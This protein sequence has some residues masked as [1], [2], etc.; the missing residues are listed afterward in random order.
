MGGIIDIRAPGRPPRGEHWLDEP[1][2]TPVSAG[3]VGQIFGI[4]LD[5]AT[6]PN[7]YVGATAAFGLHLAADGRQWMAGMWGRDGGPG[8]IYRLDAA[9]NYQPRV[10]ANVTLNGRPNTGAALGNLAFDRAHRQLFASDLETGFIHRFREADGV[11]LGAYDHGTQGR[12]RFVDA[13]S[14][15]LKSLPPLVFDPATRARIADCPAGDFAR[16]PECWNLAASGRRTWGIAVR[17]DVR[18][19]EVRLYYSVWSGPGPGATDWSR[20]PDDEKQNA[21]WSVRIA[22]DGAFDLTDVRRE[23]LV[24]AFFTRPEEVARWGYSH[25]VSD[26]AFSECGDRNV[27]LL[28]ER[29]GLRNLGL[30]A[31]N[32]FARPHEARALRYALDAGGGWRAAG[33]Y[34]VGFYDRRG[35]GQPY[36]RANCA[37]GVAFGY[38]YSPGDWSID[39]ARPDQT[40]WLSGDVLCSAK[41]PCFAPGSEAAVDGSEVNGIQGTPAGMADELLPPEAARAYP[42][43]GPPYPPVGLAQSYLID[44]DINVGSDGQVERSGLTRNDATRIGDVAIYEPCAREAQAPPPPVPRPAAPARPS[45][46]TLLKRQVDPAC[47]PGSACTFEVMVTNVGTDVWSGLLRLM[48][49]PPLGTA[50]LSAS[51]PWRCVAIGDQ[52]ACDYPQGVLYPGQQLGLTL[53]MQLPL[54][55]PQGSLNCVEGTCIV[56]TTTPP[57]PPSAP[58]LTV[59]KSQVEEVCAPGGACSFNVVLAN[60]SPG[61]WSGIPRII[62]TLPPGT[63][64]LSASEP[65]ACAPL[66]EQVACE[67]PETALNPGDWLV[68]T[69]TVQLPADM[70]QGSVNCADD[71]CIVITSTPPFPPPAPPPNIT[72]TKAQVEPACT[73]G[74]PCTFNVVLTNSGAGVFADTARVTDTLP[75]G[76]TAL[77]AS[78]PWACAPDGLQVTC[79]YPGAVLNPGEA[80]TLTLTVQLPPDLPAGS[81]NCAEGA[82]IPINTT[83]PTPVPTPIPTPTPTPIPTP[84]PTP[85]PTP[86]TPRPGSCDEALHPG[87]DTPETI[88]IAVTNRPGQA[89]FKFNT[90]SKKDRILV[91]VDGQNVLDTTCVGSEGTRDVPLTLPPGAQNVRVRVEPNCEPGTGTGTQWELQ[92]V[93]PPAPQPPA[94]PLISRP[95]PSYSPPA[96]VRPPVVRSPPP[97]VYVPPVHAPPPAVYAPPLY[98]PPDEVPPDYVPPPTIYE[99]PVYPLPPL[100]VPPVYVPPVYVP[101]LGPPH[102]PPVLPPRPPGHCEPGQV[103]PPLPGGHPPGVGPLLPPTP[104]VRPPGGHLPGTSPLLPP[105]PGVRPPGGHLPGT[106]PLLPPTPG[107][108]PPGGHLPG[109]SPLLPPTPGVRP[110]G[111]HMP[112][113][114]PLLPPT[115]GVRP[116]GGH[117]PGTSP[118]LPPTPG[119]RPPGG[120]LPGTS[121]LLPPTPGVRPPGGHLPGTSPL[122]PPTP[123]VRPPGGHLPGTSPLLPPTPGVRPPGGHLPGAPATLPAPGARPP[124][125]HLPGAPATLPA[126]GA[127]PP[128][129]HLPGAPTTLPTQPG[130]RP[131]S[132]LLPGARPP[133]A[134]AALPTQPGAHPPGVRAPSG[135]LTGPTRPGLRPANRPVP[136]APGP[137][138]R[139]QTHSGRPGAVTAPPTRVQPTRPGVP[140]R[141]V[142]PVRP[143]ARP[144]GAAPSRP[145]PSSRAVS[146]SRPGTPRAVAPTRPNARPG[147]PSRPNAPPRAA[148]PAHPAAPRAV[149]PPRPSVPRAAPAARP[150]PCRPGMRC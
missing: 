143:G 9:R 149:A 38:G 150:Q 55:L 67:Y 36:V 14:G 114:S 37:G 147:V 15:Q 6:P 144:Q 1:Q 116:P 25:P 134:P 29:G 59:T 77:S 5:D 108:R 141:Q 62:D 76:V 91:Y 30:A 79:E 63:T 135:T 18:T 129:G 101:P 133:G 43:A 28:G 145:H 102:Y 51:A 41:G 47:L 66:G 90:F 12:P 45:T 69:L 106:S 10:F 31:E 78:E 83:P 52:V 111:G 46:L 98:V 128:G 122:L 72:V 100:Y 64:P 115:P 58:D 127:R 103:C 88:D 97:N 39:R 17:S 130:G 121:P 34:D 73:A 89:T 125:G 132:G 54:D 87:G 8:T 93:C 50:V 74:G 48:D 94:T 84:T 71:T 40:A 82:C 148:A 26:I 32:A 23:L 137:G 120:H 22:Q 124:G 68:L 53:T 146:P 104:G 138:P 4:A 11:D 65:W 136:A 27:M 49:T 118:L 61:V 2:R 75:P 126:P 96:Y 112:G 109:T 107:V 142:A 86:E 3:E 13:P 113:T 16:A 70:P 33:R 81:V 92:L 110:P 95:P 24:P 42:P 57:P 117:L 44:T 19:G 140:T 7:I 99:P 80:L 119:V 56:I 131:P 139:T 85:T 21:V 123:G 20:L 60:N 35:E 105:T